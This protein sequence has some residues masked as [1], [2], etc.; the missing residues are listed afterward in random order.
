MVMTLTIDNAGR[1]L[2]PKPIRDRLGWRAG[3]DIEVIE[4]PD[5]VVLKPCVDQPAMEKVNGLWVHGG[6]MPA[7]FDWDR[8]VQEEREGQSRVFATEP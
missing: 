3:V 1:I 4:T 5:G 7:R 6:R 2:I 8:F